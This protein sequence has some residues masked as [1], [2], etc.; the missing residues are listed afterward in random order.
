M[1]VRS[2][3]RSDQTTGTSGVKKT[4][5]STFGFSVR[6]PVATPGSNTQPPQIA[7]NKEWRGAS[8]FWRR[9]VAGTRSIGGPWHDLGSSNV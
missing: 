8:E 9:A 2:S 4:E 1:R 6:I 5:H 7:I 3:Y